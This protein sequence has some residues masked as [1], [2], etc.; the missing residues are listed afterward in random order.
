MAKKSRKNQKNLIYGLIIAGLALLTIIPIFASIIN[1]SD[2][3]GL[4][5]ISET[6]ADLIKVIFGNESATT[7][8]MAISVLL[9]GDYAFITTVLMWG[10]LITLISAV[11]TILFQLLRAFGFKLKML[12]NIF[13]YVFALCAIITFVFAI[14]VSNA[15]V[16]GIVTVSSIGVGAYFLLSGVIASVIQLV[17]TQKN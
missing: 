12:T 10:F 13:T 8:T 6:G 1:V 4:T 7:G 17:S 2:A 5:A 14:L 16:V 9:E 11:G 15:Q 3:L